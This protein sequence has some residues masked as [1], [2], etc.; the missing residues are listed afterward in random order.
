MCLLTNEGDRKG[1]E[2]GI[3]L[4]KWKL[5]FI[6][7]HSKDNNYK[8]NKPIKLARTALH[9]L[10]VN[11]WRST[12]ETPASNEVKYIQYMKRTAL[13]SKLNVLYIKSAILSLSFDRLAFLV[14][15]LL[16][17]CIVRVNANGFLNLAI[18]FQSWKLNANP[19]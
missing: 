15:R 12:M 6:Y 16:R 18:V 17:V 1:N 11:N 7:I 5:V 19:G 8:P 4:G 14:D 9:Y 10:D 3:L 13:I 2:S